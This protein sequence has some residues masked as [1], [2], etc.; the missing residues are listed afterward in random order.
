MDDLYKKEQKY[1]KINKNNTF[2]F[3][4]MS[5]VQK[6]EQKFGILLN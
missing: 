5:E 3:I 2:V 6:L 1:S 4:K